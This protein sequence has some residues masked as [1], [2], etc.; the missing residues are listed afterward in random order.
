[1]PYSD[2]IRALLDRLQET[3]GLRL[4]LEESEEADDPG[5]TAEKLRNLLALTRSGRDKHSFLSRFLTEP[6]EEDQVRSGFARHH[7][8]ADA[9]RALILVSFPD[10]STDEARRI[11]SSIFPRSRVSPLP[12][13]RESILLIVKDRFSD[14]SSMVSTLLDTMA[15]EAMVP[16]KIT[17]SDQAR[18][19]ADLPALYRD[20]LTS[21]SIGNTFYPQKQVYEAGSLG[22]ARLVYALPEAPCRRYLLEHFGTYDLGQLDPDTL[23]AIHTLF[24]N[25][26]SLS[27]TAR[28]LFVHRN[29]LAYRLD[30]F[31]K[32]SGLDVRDFDDAVTCR[33]GMMIWQKLHRD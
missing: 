9:P 15:S 26:L 21:L 14:I 5:A 12:I 28:R 2:E 27:E 33:I 4:C 18:P 19:M 16:V 3:T 6:L 8:R 11:L 20:L 13:R 29:T 24:S 25:N 7:I 1:M 17:Y 23:R 32:A 22:L 10:G 30:K 31:Q